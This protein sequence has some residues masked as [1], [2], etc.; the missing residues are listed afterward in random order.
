MRFEALVFGLLAVS[1]LCLPDY[2]FGSSRKQEYLRRIQDAKRSNA[3]KLL[4]RQKTRFER[5]Q[6]K[7]PTRNKI[8]QR[9]PKKLINQQI[10]EYTNPNKEFPVNY[11]VM[12]GYTLWKIIWTGKQWHCVSTVTPGFTPTECVKVNPYTGE[13]KSLKTGKIVF[14]PQGLTSA[15]TTATGAQ[16]DPLIRM[17]RNKCIEYSRAAVEVKYASDGNSPEEGF[18]AL[19]LIDYIYTK[20][21]Y[22]PKVDTIEDLREKFGSKINVDLDGVLPGDLLFFRLYS[23]KKKKSTL[24]AAICVDKKEMIYSSFTRNKVIARTYDLRFWRKNFEG[25]NRVFVK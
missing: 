7:R 6:S 16:L 17:S 24:M 13:L 8:N 20:L 18:S 3:Q 4:S 14:R 5:H 19:G 1:L 25:A 22:E 9:P 21:G 10:A 2:G 12:H 23:K 15:S 11:L